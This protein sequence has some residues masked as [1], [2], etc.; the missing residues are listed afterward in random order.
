DPARR[1]E[2][3]VEGA[4]GREGARARAAGQTPPV[5]RPQPSA[6]REPVGFRP[7]PSVTAKT[8]AERREKSHVPGGG[9]NR[10][11]R[12]V[13]LLAQKRHELRDRFH[14]AHAGT[15]APSRDA[16][17]SMSAKARPA[18]SCFLSARPCRA[19]SRGR[20]SNS[21]KF[22]FIGWKRAGSHSRR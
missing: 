17:R 12:I 2:E 1:S 8:G 10:M 5:H 7:P 15:A 13:A 6:D 4:Q 11:R 9:P 21:P 3:P 16:N 14:V 22:A 20:G 19:V 18:S